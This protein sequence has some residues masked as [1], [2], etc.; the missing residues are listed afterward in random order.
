MCSCRDV[1]SANEIFVSVKKLLWVI[2]SD[3]HG[4]SKIA[5]Y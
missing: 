3:I 4:V 2:Y 1:V 5:R